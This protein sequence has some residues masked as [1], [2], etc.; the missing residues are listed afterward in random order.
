MLIMRPEYMTVGYDIIIKYKPTYRFVQLVRIMRTM[1][2]HRQWPVG[3]V[4]SGED[5]DNAIHI[6]VNRV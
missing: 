3:E 5:S 1:D 4:H 2:R 6:M